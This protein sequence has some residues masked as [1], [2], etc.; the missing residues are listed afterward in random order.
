MATNQ[1]AQGGGVI[2]LTLIV[3]MIVMLLPLPETLRLVRPEWV[4][5]TLMYWALALPYRVGVGYAWVVGLMTDIV[6][7]GTLGIFAFAYA[8]VIYIIVRFHQQLRQFPM[9]QQALILMAMFLSV[10]LITVLMTIEPLTWHIWL[11][12]ISSTL[13]WPV[14]YGLLRG[15][16][17]SF[18][19]R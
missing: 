13:L 9:W 6:T 10:Q 16:R 15:I 2:I 14:F 3:A 18:H 7:G 4:L 5:L 8:F 19:V 1:H 11:P 12:A 17:R